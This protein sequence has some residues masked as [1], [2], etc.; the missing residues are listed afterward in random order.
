MLGVGY[1]P[2]ISLSVEGELLSFCNLLGV[3]R[4]QLSVVRVVED[5]GGDLAFDGAGSLVVAL[6]YHNVK[7]MVV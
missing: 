2:G 5:C 7:V 3:Q 4:H 6:S 1:R